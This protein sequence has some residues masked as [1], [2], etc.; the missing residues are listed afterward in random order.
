MNSTEYFISLIFN[1]HFPVNNAMLL[2]VLYNETV[3]FLSLICITWSKFEY[4]DDNANMYN[5]LCLKLLWL[6]SLLT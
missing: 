6:H 5:C 1:Y 3:G 2:H 4:C